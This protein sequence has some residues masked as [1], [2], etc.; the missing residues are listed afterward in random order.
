MPT[1]LNWRRLAH[2][3]ADD[4]YQQLTGDPGYFDTRIVFVAES[5]PPLERKRRLA[6]MD[7]DGANPEFLLSGMDAVTTPRFSPS[8][9]TI[10]YAAYVADPRNPNATLLR[11][12]LYDLET[13]RPEA[14]ATRPTPPA[15]PRASLPMAAMSR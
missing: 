13:G 11:T 14:L 5:G 2:K 12:Y 4:I 10:I 8:S 9:Q 6:I 1:P 3:I 7:Q 15:M